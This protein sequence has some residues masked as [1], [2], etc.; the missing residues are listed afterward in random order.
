M[1]LILSI[2]GSKFRYSWNVIHILCKFQLI[3]KQHIPF[4][5]VPTNFRMGYYTK[6]T[7]D[8]S[9]LKLIFVKYYFN[10]IMDM[11]IFFI[12]LLPHN[13]PTWFNIFSNSLHNIKICF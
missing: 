7:I 4:N 9:I 1:T 2:S 8:N 6:Q 11:K 3:K 12:R 10:F 13:I 5:L